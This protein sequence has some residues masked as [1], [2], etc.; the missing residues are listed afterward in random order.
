MISVIIPTLNSELDLPKTLNALVPAAIEG[1]IKEVIIVDGGSEDLTLKIADNAGA[2]IISCERGRGKQLKT[3]AYEARYPW[4][5]FL[6]ADT[7]LMLGWESIVCEFVEKIEKMKLNSQAAAFRFKLSDSGWRPKLLEALVALRCWL[8]KLPYGDQG[9]LISR[10]LYDE[11]GGYNCQPIMEDI[12]I[13]RRLG[14]QR[15]RLLPVDAKTSAR[16]YKQEGYFKRT[17]RNQICII[18]YI[19]GIK[20]EHIAHFYEKTE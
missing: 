11:I 2:K 8:L 18:L 1:I 6:H 10:S 20:R 4:L 19:I 7:E 17:L 14:R 16:R 9:L 5:L 15:I 12:D 13:I 3:G